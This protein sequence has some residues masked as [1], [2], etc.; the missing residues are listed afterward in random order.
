MTTALA[1]RFK[2]DV[3]ADNITWLNVKGINDLNP[4]ENPTTVGADTYDTNGFN[5][6]EK[7]M[8]GW[9]VVVKALRSTIGAAFDPGQEL[10]R[11]TR[12]QFGTTAR[13]YVRWYDRNG[14][15][16]AYAGLAIVDYAP[17]KTGVADLD[18]IAMTFKGDGVLAPI[19][20]PYNAS[21]VPVVLSATPSGA[22]VGQLVLI[23]GANFT[24]VVPATGVKFGA[25]TATVVTVLGDS[26]LIA[27]MPTGTA[28]V[29]NVTV[30]NP[31]GAS[32]ALTYVRG[33]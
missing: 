15:P 2:F 26:Q 8:T 4:Q 33:A 11:T 20:N 5:A 27:V 21:A 22:S 12:F 13:L 28:G 17:S 19:T 31:I 14:A 18:E 32:A 10:V 24:G 23:S 25:V 16:E 7:T 1:R 3:S 30:T 6:F 9:S 29:A